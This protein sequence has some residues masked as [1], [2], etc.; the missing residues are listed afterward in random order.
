MQLPAGDD[1]NADQ[2]AYWNGPGGQRWSDRQAAQDILLAPVSQIL[3]DRIAAKPGDRILDV[4]CGCGG[5]AIALAAR[6]APGGHV[7]GVD[8]SAPMLER[9]RAVARA[10]LP[11]EFVLA[12]AT[13]HPFAPASFD[14]LVSRFGV[15]FFA[16]PVA[17]FANMRRALKPGGRVVFAC[18]REPKANPWM[19]A[20][21]QAVYRHV[22]KL[23][24]MAPEDPGP[25]AFASEARVTRILGEAGFND[26][27]LEAHALSLDIA[28]GNGLDA[29]VQSAFEI[30]P[31]SRALEGHPPA[32]REAARQSVRDLLAQHL[33]GDSVPLAGSIWL[34]TAGA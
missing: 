14:L 1:R 33:A 24:E 27:A 32:T 5:L 8:I 13:V 6:V 25:F 28:L 15:M 3:I 9:A 12:D 30:G 31:A 4:G 20:P 23:P 22:P 10:G 7:L 19:I 29:A 16:D 18:W 21:L 34:V 11:V 26:V 2:I 17:S